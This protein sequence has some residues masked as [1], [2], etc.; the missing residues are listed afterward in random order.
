MG[1]YSK[2]RTIVLISIFVASI[3]F[4]II[5]VPYMNSY[6]DSS[7]KVIIAAVITYILFLYIVV[8]GGIGIYCLVLCIIT[9]EKNLAF[10]LWLILISVIIGLGMY[11]FFSRDITSIIA[12][13]VCILMSSIC[14][15]ISIKSM[16]KE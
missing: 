14:L 7:Y 6:F 4:E 16:K 2:T 10:S 5:M 3:I 12:E 1:E 11:C 13:C 15:L 9:K 8:F